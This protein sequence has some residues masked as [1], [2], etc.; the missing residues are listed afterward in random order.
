MIKSCRNVKRLLLKHKSLYTSLGGI[1]GEHFLCLYTLKMRQWRDG[2]HKDL[3]PGHGVEDSS[4][5]VK[6]YALSD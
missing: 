1:E 5:G 6:E 2:V 3:F 4:S